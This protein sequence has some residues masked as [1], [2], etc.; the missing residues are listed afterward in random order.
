MRMRKVVCAGNL[1]LSARVKALSQHCW[2]T[3]KPHSQ[4]QNPGTFRCLPAI[5]SSWNKHGRQALSF[6]SFHAVSAPPSHLSQ[7]GL[8]F[9]LA[10]YHSPCDTY[11]YTEVACTS[12]QMVTSTACPNSK[13]RRPR[14]C[15]SLAICLVLFGQAV[16]V[17]IS[18]QCPYLH[19]PGVADCRRLAATGSALE[20]LQRRFPACPQPR[21]LPEVCQSMP[22]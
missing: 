4:T 18:R 16:I 8:C 10:L 11:L 14:A 17:T 7:P 15:T 13:G 6:R 21:C 1:H 2:C 22:M 19:P 9:C 12:L 3:S 20:P 5:P